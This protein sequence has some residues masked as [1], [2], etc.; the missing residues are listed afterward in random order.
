MW[1]AFIWALPRIWV[2]DLHNY[3]IWGSP[4]CPEFSRNSQK[5][6]FSWTLNRLLQEKHEN[7]TFI[8]KVMVEFL[9]SPPLI[10]FRVTFRSSEWINYN[11][12][13]NK[14]QNVTIKKTWNKEQNTERKKVRKTWWFNNFFSF[15]V[16]PRLRLAKDLKI[17]EER[18]ET[19]TS[20]KYEKNAYMRE[21]KSELI[22]RL[23]W[24][25]LR[26]SMNFFVCGKGKVVGGL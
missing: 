9:D 14:T 6:R 16:A 4:I 12:D 3:C 21:K 8:Q 7:F 26:W 11:S 17:R 2:L 13:Y 22:D 19:L 18:S 25:T 24:V 1:F 5:N 23:D 15:W 10:W 20:K